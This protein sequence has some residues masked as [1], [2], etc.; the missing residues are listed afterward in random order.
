MYMQAV[1]W[2]KDVEV[3][4]MPATGWRCSGRRRPAS[5]LSPTYLIVAHW[6]R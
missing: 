2:Q 5:F 3:D 1:Q 4:E 6:R